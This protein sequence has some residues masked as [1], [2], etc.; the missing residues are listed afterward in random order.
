MTTAPRI[1]FIGVDAAEK[2]LIL[3]WAKVIAYGID[4]LMQ[5]TKT[6]QLVLADIRSGRFA[7]Q[8]N[9]VSFKEYL[10]AVGY[11][12]WERVESRSGGEQSG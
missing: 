4:L 12:D 2:V 6:M 3:E 8:G 5:I 11:D 7:L 10:S 1:L 9:G